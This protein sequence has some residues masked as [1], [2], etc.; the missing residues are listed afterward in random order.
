M[1]DLRDE[2]DA[3]APGAVQGVKVPRPP[4]PQL[5]EQYMGQGNYGKV[6]GKGRRRGRGRDVD[7]GA[8][9]HTVGDA[10][11]QLWQTSREGDLRP[12]PYVPRAPNLQPVVSDDLCCCINQFALQ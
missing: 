3:H 11:K 2:C 5:A 6:G 8:S 1:D 10:E 4:E 12:L 9:M 7:Q